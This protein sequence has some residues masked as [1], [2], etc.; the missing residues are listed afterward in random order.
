MNKICQKCIAYCN[1]SKS[2][3]NLI[4]F[5][6]KNNVK[7]GVELEKIDSNKLFFAPAGNYPKNPIVTICGLATSVQAKDYIENDIK[8]NKENKYDSCLRSVYQGKM[9]INLGFIMKSI[10]IEKLIRKQIEIKIDENIFDLN[11]LSIAELKKANGRFTNL[12]NELQLT[13]STC[14]WSQ[15]NKST[16]KKEWWR[17]SKECRAEGY[18]ANIVKRFSRS[19]KSKVLL[20][21]GSSNNQN[22]KIINKV[23]HDNQSKAKHV[24]FLTPKKWRKDYQEYQKIIVMMHHPANTGFVYNNYKSGNYK[25]LMYNYLINMNWDFKSNNYGRVREETYRN[26]KEYYEYISERVMDL[27]I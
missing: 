14:C 17:Y 13:Q 11:N 1:D 12:P 25:S 20:I 7:I 10:N 2:D 9:A 16:F 24:L 21:L 8:K 15:N 27:A 5:S 4:D 22:E 3:L 18:F 6:E 19:N 23:M 26:V